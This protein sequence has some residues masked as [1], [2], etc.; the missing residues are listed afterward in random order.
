M[1]CIIV[2]GRCCRI[3]RALINIH[4][5]G[6]TSLFEWCISDNFDDLNKIIEKNTQENNIEMRKDYL[7]HS[8]QTSS[9]WLTTFLLII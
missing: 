2:L 8:P 3:T 6:K 9:S 5:K 1:V 4:V 7:K